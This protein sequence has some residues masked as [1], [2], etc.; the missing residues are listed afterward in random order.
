VLP[1]WPNQ[2]LVT[3]SA[4]HVAVLHRTGLTKKVLAQHEHAVTPNPEHI[5]QASLQTLARILVELAAPRHTA[6]QLTLESDLVRY[7]VLPPTLKHISIT[8]KT[9]YAQAAFREVFGAEVLNWAIQCDDVAPAK[10]TMCAA[11]DLTLL[12]ELHTL[13]EK[14]SIVL[15]SV[16]PYFVRAINGLANALHKVEGVVAM[17][18]HSRLVFATFHHGICTQIRSQAI[19]LDWQQQLPEILARTM[20]LEDDVARVI[21]IYAP[22][23]KASALAPITHWQIKRLGLS[24]K[25]ALPQTAYPLLEVMA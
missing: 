8:E 3:L 12:I 18:E 22:A 11:I 2:L 4:T 10:P 13:A 14:Q 21:S 1:L 15:K 5:W 16:Q 23:H 20:V 6:M 25:Q 7:L 24:N 17:V 19:A 9:A